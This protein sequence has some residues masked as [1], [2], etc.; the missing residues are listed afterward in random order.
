MTTP[1]AVLDACVL[2]PYRTMSTLLWLAEAGLFQPLWSDEI[3]N[4]VERNLP[5]LGLTPDQIGRRIAAMREAFDD[6]ALIEGHEPLIDDMTNQAKDRHVLA[7]AVHEQAEFVVTTNLKDFP[8]ESH[9]PHDVQVLSPDDFLLLLLSERPVELIETL[10][11]QVKMLRDPPEDLCSWLCGLTDITPT[12][13]SLAADV[14]TTP[15]QP[16]S[17]FPALM[18]AD[19]DKAEEAFGELYDWTDPAQVALGW[20]SALAG[21]NLVL[22]R[23]LTYRPRA[24]DFD[25][26]AA[27]LAPW[28]LASKV[29]PVIDAPDDIVFMRFV[30]EVSQAAQVIESYV[31]TM[32]FLTLVKVGHDWRVWSLGSRLLPTRVMRGD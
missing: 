15:Q 26:V 18:A 14:A 28:S 3:L 19:P 7:A 29:I 12:F 8:A 22:V 25:A 16:M 32:R 11:A 5:S 31:T 9:E 21:G 13:A 30:P 1:A 4:E 24:W 23:Q 17:P 6:I 20:A 10:H 2:I 27:E